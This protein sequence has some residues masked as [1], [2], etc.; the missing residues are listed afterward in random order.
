M[1]TR[2]DILKGFGT[3]AGLTAFGGIAAACS[4]SSSTKTSSSD[5]KGVINLRF[6]NAGGSA[7]A[8][9]ACLTKWADLCQEKS[10]GR[11]KVSAYN[12]GQLGAEDQVFTEITAGSVDGAATATS[13]F[14]SLVPQ[15][16][17]F[18]LPW[19]APDMDHMVN[20][21]RGSAGTK[22]QA[23]T[24]PKGIQT[25][26]FI[27][28][29]VSG[30]I[31]TSKTP[32][33]TPQDFRGIKIRTKQSVLLTKIWTDLGAIPTPIDTAQIYL[34]LQRGLLSAG[35]VSA[36]YTAAEKWY[37]VAHSYANTEHG[38][39]GGAIYMS[40]KTYAGLPADMQKVVKE[41]AD[42][43]SDYEINL[44]K[45]LTAKAFVT[46]KKAGLDVAE[47]VDKEPFMKATQNIYQQFRS[48]IGGSFQDEVVAAARK[49]A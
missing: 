25:L 6:A 37:E 41:A 16:Q 14:Y 22:L 12:N 29:G 19:L 45:S 47:N 34:S 17:A 39:G 2:R 28:S 30:V 36:D 26:A 49:S 4:S 23:L 18:D 10:N 43:A 35:D 31:S 1:Q 40:Q 32:P 13:Y 46:M 24:A 5:A 15:F 33:V 44:M 9:G 48:Q 21:M 20:M 38:F 3:A 42:E 8:L 11:L 27:I 7:S